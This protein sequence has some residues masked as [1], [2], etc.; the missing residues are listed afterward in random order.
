VTGGD[1]VVHVDAPDARVRVTLNG[2]DVTSAFSA[3][4]GG[5]TGLV[6][7]L[8]LGSNVLRAEADGRRTTLE[9]RN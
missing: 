6:G 8:R 9:V 5:L 1:A 4:D 3:D 7:N 2:V